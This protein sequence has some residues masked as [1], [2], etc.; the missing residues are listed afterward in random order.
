M[1]ASQL[2]GRG[3]FQ[4]CLNYILLEDTY[5]WLEL[6]ICSSFIQCFQ[7]ILATQ[8]KELLF[9]GSMRTAKT[10]HSD[11]LNSNQKLLKKKLIYRKKFENILFRTCIMQF[12][13]WTLTAFEPDFGIGL[14]FF[15]FLSSWIYFTLFA[16]PHIYRLE[17]INN[18]ETVRILLT[19]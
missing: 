3:S 2:D 4:E 9:L 16:I 10:C 5:H 15:Y 1:G 18:D 7:K 6:I 14:F 19:F 17:I 13:S 8:I 12:Y 11:P